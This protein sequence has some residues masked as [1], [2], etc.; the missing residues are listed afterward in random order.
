MRVNVAS[1]DGSWESH[2]GAYLEKDAE[3]NKTL[4]HVRAQTRYYTLPSGVGAI[5]PNAF[6]D[7][8]KVETIIL[9][10]GEDGIAIDPNSFRSS[11]V[12]TILCGGKAQA[13]NVQAQ[14]DAAGITDVRAIVLQTNSRGETYYTDERSAEVVLMAG[15]P[16]KTEFDGTIQDADGN[17]LSVTTLADGAFAGSQKLQW[18]ILPGTLTNIGAQAFYGCSN[19]EG[20][21]IDANGEA[22]VGNA[23]FDNCTSLNFIASNAP[24]INMGEYA[25]STGAQA[26]VMYSPTGG[27]GYGEDWTYF[28]EESGVQRYDVV[29]IGSTKML[30]GAS[31][32]KDWL[33]LRAGRHTEGE[34]A[35]PEET[36]ELFDKAFYGAEDS[37]TINWDKL[38]D[39]QYIDAYVFADSGLE[40]EVVTAVSEVGEAAFQS[41][42]I[43]KLELNGYIQRLDMNSF[44]DCKSL[45]G[46]SITRGFEN[47]SSIYTGLFSA[48]SAL[49][50]I[51]IADFGNVPQL[52]TF[53][54]S[55]AFTFNYEWTWQ[56]TLQRVHIRSDWET[57]DDIAPSYVKK[58]R[59]SLLGSMD[60]PN[61]TGYMNL[62]DNTMMDLMFNGTWEDLY[63]ETDAAVKQKLVDVEND[64]RTMLGAE[65][66]VEEPSEFYPYRV[67]GDYITLIGAPSDKTTIDL[68]SETLGL[69]DGW[70]L[71]YI[72]EGAFSN[73]KNLEYLVL[74]SGL[75]GIEQDAFRGVESDTLT[76][77]FMDGNPPELLNFTPGEG[78]SF[79]IDESRIKIYI[80]AWGD[81]E[82]YLRFIEKWIYP[83]AGYE[84]YAEMYAA[85]A[86]GMP[87]AAEEEIYAKMEEILLPV[88]NRIRRMLW[89]REWIP[90]ASEFEEGTTVDTHYPEVDKLSFELAPKKQEPEMV[91]PDDQNRNPEEDDDLTP[92]PEP[93]P[94]TDTDTDT[95]NG[96][97]SE[98][99]TIDD[100]AANEP[101][102][103]STGK[104]TGSADT[105]ADDATVLPMPDGRHE[106]VIPPEPS[107][108][109]STED[110]STSA[111]DEGETE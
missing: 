34:L 77:T 9:P 102:G 104:D 54:A 64:I 74:E 49:E 82:A 75:A 32:G 89:H 70:C 68:D 1:S 38:P 39:L 13:E 59:Y 14:L 35:L 43:T 106:I 100:D 45:T 57:G 63:A 67:R 95:S 86:A 88:E 28:V 65:T 20:I 81:E 98:P 66:K 103:D 111:E 109:T 48:C 25:V 42:N 15:D 40:G 83:M 73:T 46:V 22:S 41:T 108:S 55:S 10:E 5:G 47:N 72:G 79:G 26:T 24:S 44:V 107:D 97:T 36:V 23:A 33:G 53:S 50:D 17:T 11:N 61:A 91:E 56:D 84:N 99:P 80:L 60:T 58:W 94:G 71:D 2:D 110:N 12:D 101:A 6:A 76:M 90:G 37:F 31:D 27:I 29:D 18:A 62:W 69:L 7:A 85:V 52:L 93:N 8:E 3:G 19:L 78:Y 21:M 92:V 4:T 16:A 51:T 87:D 96:N 30:Y 105:S